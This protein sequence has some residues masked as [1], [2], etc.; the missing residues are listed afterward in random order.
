MAERVVSAIIVHARTQ[1]NNDKRENRL[2]R[3]SENLGSA[4]LRALMEGLSGY[5][6]QGTAARVGNNRRLNEC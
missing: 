4:D 5:D 2:S 6:R 1:N 3:F